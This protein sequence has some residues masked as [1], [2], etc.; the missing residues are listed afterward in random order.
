MKRWVWA[1]VAV[2]VAVLVGGYAYSNHQITENQYRTEMSNGKSAIQDKQY[3]KA[4]SHFENALKRKTNDSAAQRYLDQTQ[5]FVSGKN[6][7]TDRHFQSAKDYFT[8]VKNTQ[9]TSGILVSRAKSRLKTLKI[10]M[11]NV[12][13]YNKLYNE[14]VTQNKAMEYEASNNTLNQLFSD[15]EFSKAYYKNIYEKAKDLQEA[16]NKGMTGESSTPSTNSSS[17]SSTALTESEK[18]AADAYQGSNE[19][20]VP[21]SQTQINGQTITAAQINDA[22][23]T[24]QSVGVQP[25]QFSDQDIRTGLIAANKQGISFKAYAEKTYK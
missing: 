17:S 14:A 3:T 10:V 15:T 21:K 11:A 23:S 4:E 7:M 19:Y 16:N 12:K 5:A 22:R 9:N 13:K 25:G 18:Q 1:V 8:T 20:T 24:L 2:V 6:A